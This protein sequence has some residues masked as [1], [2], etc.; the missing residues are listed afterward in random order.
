MIFGLYYN[1]VWY[2]N[3]HTYKKAAERNLK[4][5]GEAMNRILKLE[6]IFPIDKAKKKYWYKK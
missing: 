3:K 1:C 4:I 5:I 6:I 2:Y